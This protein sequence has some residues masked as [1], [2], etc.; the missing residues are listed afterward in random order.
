MP[1]G[2]PPGW[3]PPPGQPFHHP[4]PGQFY[5][6]QPPIGSVPQPQAAHGPPGPPTPTAQQAV[7]VAPAGHEQAGHEQKT[8]PEQKAPEQKL[9]EGKLSEQK[10]SEGKTLD[11]TLPEQKL[12][13]GKTLEQTIPEQK[14]SERKISEQA[15]IEPKVSE[16]RAPEQILPEKPIA[17]VK[18][19][20]ASTT[21]GTPAVAQS[22][23]PPPPTD[24]KPNVTA[25]LAPPASAARKLG[26]PLAKP[27]PTGPKNGR[28]MP[29]IPRLSP[30]IKP[31]VPVNGSLLSTS[32]NVD[33]GNNKD[34]AKS[35]ATLPSQIGSRKSFGDTNRDA[36]A[37]IAAA[38]AKLPPAPGQKKEKEV[39]G[40]SA[41][42]NLTNKVNEM[43]TNDTNRAPRQPGAGDYVSSHRGG[44]SGYRGGRPQTEHTKKIQVP[45][46]DYDFASANAKFNKQD[47][48]K[49]AIATGSSRGSPADPANPNDAS[50][51]LVN[52]AQKG[53][54]SNAIIPPVASY[55]KT[56][57]F[58]DNISSESKDR[59][60]VT[61]KKLGGREFRSEE[62][63]KNLET[64]GQGSV[65]NGYRGSFR[66]RGR[67]RG[68]GRP[69]G[70]Y[71]RGGRGGTRGFHGAG[72][73]TG[74]P[75]W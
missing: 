22:T 15:L 68:Y 72:V 4:P 44:R 40:E 41:V 45:T 56:S 6:P 8:S 37:A 14:L 12:S 20:S 54:E 65:D 51:E 27:V 5:P 35:E 53:S 50:V 66:G 71:G 67:G 57:S 52:G 38:M 33:S 24:T 61:G 17:T 59:D 62:Q 21:P 26:S 75:R 13:E 69:R 64:F 9:P 16:Q 42:Q 39:N 2:A 23:P 31:Y 11:Q 1:Y 7:S 63:K 25:A 60:D 55:N 32:G 73:V 46:T 3:Y 28:I 29:A 43:R 19:P 36:K 74:E 34:L 48:V 70:G 10:L 49:E 47:L 18:L 30:A 58:F